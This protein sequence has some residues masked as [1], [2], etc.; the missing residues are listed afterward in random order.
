M[1]PGDITVPKPHH[2][3]VL[4][5]YREQD[6][7]RAQQEGGREGS[8]RKMVGGGKMRSWSTLLVWFRKDE[9]GP[10]Q[11]HRELGNHRGACHTGR[12]QNADSSDR[13]CRV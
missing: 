10:G 2:W 9:T 6:G 13:E 7:G 4:P 5:S 11:Q 12:E 1:R 3:G 8:E